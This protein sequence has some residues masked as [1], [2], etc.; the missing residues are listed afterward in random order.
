LILIDEKYVNGS[1]KIKQTK[2]WKPQ[3]RPNIVSQDWFLDCC[4]Q[5]K[6]LDAD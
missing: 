5:G 6:I 3:N 2:N 1:A 4:E